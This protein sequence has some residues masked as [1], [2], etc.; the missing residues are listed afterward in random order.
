LIEV[1]RDG[2]SL[3]WLTAVVRALSRF[4]DWDAAVS[5]G[6]GIVLLVR[7]D[8]VSISGWRTPTEDPERVIAELRQHLEIRAGQRVRTRAAR[9]REVASL[10]PTSWQAS[11]RKGVE[12]V[13]TFSTQ[14]DGDP[15]DT[16]W[17]LHFG[18]QSVFDLDEYV[19]EPDAVRPSVYWTDANGHLTPYSAGSRPT[20]EG[21]LMAEWALVADGRPIRGAERLRVS[22]A[23]HSWVF[24]LHAH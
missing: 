5:V 13:A 3:A 22:K 6:E 9:V 16:V 14:S 19:F 7:H 21:S 17:L 2:L 15:G 10:V 8:G 11:E 24:S 20:G 4:A 1:H 23:G 12:I 18:D